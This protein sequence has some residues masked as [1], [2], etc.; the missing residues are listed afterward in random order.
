MIGRVR[1]RGGAAMP[2]LGMGTWRMGENHAARHEEVAALRL[3]LDLGMALVDTAEMYGDG[4]AEEVVGEAISGRRE[5]VYLVSKVL[6]QNASR[7]GTI[8]ACEASLKRLGTGWLDL[9]LLHWPGPHPLNETF[10]A[11]A[12]LEDTGK[13]RRWGVSNF[14]VGEVEDALARPDGERLAVNQVLYNLSRRG[15]ERNLLPWCERSG[16]IVMAYSPFEQGR[17]RR[18]DALE[19]VARRHG[20][21]PMQ[22]A[23]AWT[24]RHE[25]VVAIPKAVRAEH[26]RENVAA[27]NVVLTEEDLADFDRDFP[28]PSE[29]VPLES[30]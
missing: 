11:F 26:V 30:L 16:I 21:T 25:N 12:R 27:A 17:L 14:D 1:G 7:E 5:D 22:A 19:R 24:L 10:E 2:A 4:G 3:G 29:D 9:Y 6:P 8:R 13:I 20:V 28:P 18:H 15:I 23:L